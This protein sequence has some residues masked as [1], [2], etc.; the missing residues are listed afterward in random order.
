MIKLILEIEEK[1][2]KSLFN[3]QI[4]SINVD[5]TEKSIFATEV[6]QEALKYIK[7]KIGADKK[8]DFVHKTKS[9][10]ESLL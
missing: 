8:V 3:T 2:T 6:E 4:S 7:G 5:I 10:F 1:K 9:G